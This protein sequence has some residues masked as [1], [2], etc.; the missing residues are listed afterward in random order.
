[1]RKGVIMERHDIE[2]KLYCIKSRF[3]E[4][5]RVRSDANDK[6]KGEWITTKTGT[7]IHLNEE[8][9]ADKGPKG[10]VDAINRKKSTQSSEKANRAHSPKISGIKV[11]RAVLSD[12][13]RE[14][15]EDYH[16]AD[17]QPTDDRFGWSATNYVGA[18]LGLDQKPTVLDGDSFK[19]Y[20]S[21]S[22]AKMMYRGVCNLEDDDGEVIASQSQIISDFKNAD[23]N[24]MGGGNY[25][26]GYH[27][28]GPGEKGAEEN[29]RGFADGKRSGVIECALKPDAKTIPLSKIKE[30]VDDEYGDYPWFGAVALVRGYDAIVDDRGGDRIINVL[31]RGAIVVN[32]DYK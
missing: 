30:I 8:G 32:N 1:M 9:V 20:V 25:G 22:G 16:L 15:I 24:V 4:R 14:D 6:E 29:A 23:K 3:D 18:E 13:D 7:H 10:A 31:N 27:F 21:T 5:Q 19:E 26:E 12:E 11:K 2:Y 17:Y 28:F